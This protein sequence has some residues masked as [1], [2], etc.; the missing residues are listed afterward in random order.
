MQ[1]MVMVVGFPQTWCHQS[2]LHWIS[3]EGSPQGKLCGQS[4]SAAGPLLSHGSCWA[5][6]SL[7]RTFCLQEPLVHHPQ[8]TGAFGD[9]PTMSTHSC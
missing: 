1:P 8:P 9:Q 3:A 4:T 5:A 2:P 6:T 7:N